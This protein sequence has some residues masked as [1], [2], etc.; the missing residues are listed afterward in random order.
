[1][2]LAFDAKARTTAVENRE[3]RSWR[4]IM[5]IIVGVLKSFD[6]EL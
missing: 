3:E 5:I 4:R 6:A 2:E 1:M